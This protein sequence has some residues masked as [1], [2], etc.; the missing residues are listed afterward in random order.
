MDDVFV[1]HPGDVQGSLQRVLGKGL[2]FPG[3]Q[4]FTLLAPLRG[5]FAEHSDVQL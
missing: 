4:D 5:L 3:G 2:T 1:A